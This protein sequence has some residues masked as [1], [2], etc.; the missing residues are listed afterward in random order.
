[1]PKNCAAIVIAAKHG[2][3]IKVK[4]YSGITDTVG[5]LRCKFEFRTNDWDNAS[6][7]AVFCKGNMATHPEIIDNPKGVILDDEDECAV[8][9]EVLTRD[10][11]YFSVGIWGVTDTGLRIVSDWLVFRIKDG[12]YVDSTAPIEP[13]PTVY[14]QIMMSLNTKA[15]IDHTH[16]NYV[17]FNE[18]QN[19]Q[20]TLVSGVNIKTI[21]GEDILGSGDI[22]IESGGSSGDGSG[23]V[24]D[25]TFNPESKNAQS[26]IAVAEAIKNLANDDEPITTERITDDAVT[27]DKVETEF[28]DKG[29]NFT[30]VGD[31]DFAVHQMLPLKQLNIEAYLKNKA[32]EITQDATDEAIPTAKAVYNLYKEFN[33]SGDGVVDILTTVEPA[34]VHTNEQVYGAKALDET[35]VAIDELIQEK[36]AE[37]VSG[38]NIKTINGQ[39]ILGSGDL[40]IEG[41]S[42][43]NIV[44][45]NPEADFKDNEIY[46]ANTNNF[47]INELH[48]LIL[49]KQDKGLVQEVNENSVNGA[50]PSAKAVYEYGRSI[51]REH[52]DLMSA[53][54]YDNPDE[55][56]SCQA[57]LKELIKKQDVL[58]S[59]TN[60]KTINGQ[61]ILGEGDLVIEGGSSSGSNWIVKEETFT[62]EGGEN[63][64]S[65]SF[66]LTPRTPNVSNFTEAYL[67][68][69]VSSTVS[70]THRINFDNART[71]IVPNLQIGTTPS[72]LVIH[73][74][75]IGDILC[76]QKVN[77]ANVNA[78]KVFT[79]DTTLFLNLHWSTLAA[80]QVITSVGGIM[81]R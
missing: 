31:I 40:E 30:E 64:T 41:G 49:E 25:Q 54:V 24:V 74:I 29:L 63:G 60:I 11:K 33:S 26:G 6:V 46:N 9:T 14:E 62:I 32:T 47:V 73:I 23:G 81:Y 10:A 72:R 21:N 28:F 18:I 16:D 42:S 71:Q 43:V 2:N 80:N 22:V 44:D 76:V 56:P 8:P 59:G 65:G 34:E 79:S 51:L 27:I 77:D 39:S 7:T 67:W 53:A 58:Y 20:D 37:L 48:R 12:C 15:P 3:L 78:T 61:S 5:A 4:D 38:E 55:Y 13:T 19:K 70:G 75:K 68:V 69:K 1:M 17:S 52:K 36:Q 66:A 50:Y 45:L 57:V 35:F